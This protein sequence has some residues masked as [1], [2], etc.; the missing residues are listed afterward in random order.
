[1][2][3]VGEVAPT[4]E[5]EA[6]VSGIKVSHAN[7]RKTVLVL[8]GPRTTD[9]PKEVGKAVRAEHTD[10]A[11]VF[12]AN[13]INLK[14]MGGLWKKVATA[15][16]NQNYQRMADKLSEKGTDP[17]AYVVLCCDW[18]NAVAPLF[19]IDDSNEAAAVAVLGGDGTVLG[20]ATG[21]DLPGQALALLA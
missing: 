3:Q 16:V 4:F 10:A 7:G 21:D 5:L 11:T 8:H 12:V 15:Q 2:V 6:A 19:G 18:D 14:S 13:V 1:M 20:V 9:A 17:E